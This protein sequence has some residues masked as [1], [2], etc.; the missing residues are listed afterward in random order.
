MY[1]YWN[2][3]YTFCLKIWVKGFASISVHYTPYVFESCQIIFITGSLYSKFRKK[4]GYTYEI[5]AETYLV[6]Q[7]E[8]FDI[9]DRLYYTYIQLHLL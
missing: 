2:K 3:I 9:F 8:W 5:F 4:I 7:T 6:N 1:I